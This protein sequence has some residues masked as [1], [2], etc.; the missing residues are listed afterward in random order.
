[1]LEGCVAVGKSTFLPCAS[2]SHLK[3]EEIGLAV[4]FPF[5]LVF[6]EKSFWLS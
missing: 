3:I 2:V 1:M 5:F 6:L 4:A